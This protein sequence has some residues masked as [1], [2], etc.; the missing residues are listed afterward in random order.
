MRGSPVISGGVLLP[1]WFRPSL[2]PEP[3]AELLPLAASR[4]SGESK[5]MYMPMGS[6]PFDE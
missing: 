4:T 2:P 1:P 3:P 6:E 5:F